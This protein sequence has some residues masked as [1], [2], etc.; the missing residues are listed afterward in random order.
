MN[1]EL[2]LLGLLRE[3]RRYGYELHEFLEHSLHYQAA[4]DRPEAYAALDQLAQRGLV[5]CEA[6]QGDEYPERHVYAITPEGERV[7]QKLL[8]EHLCSAPRSFY[9]TDAGL[10]FLN[11]VPR[12]VL[13]T[14]LETKRQQLLAQR[15]ALR[16]TLPEYFDHPVA[17][18]IEHKIALLNAELAWF[19][20]FIV[21]LQD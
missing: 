18:A 9:H 20:E 4:T 11:Q 12:S 5:T 13:I 3:Q 10:L 15:D 6:G 19:E 21:R 16:A 2:L 1:H 7:F 17:H 8:V 14:C